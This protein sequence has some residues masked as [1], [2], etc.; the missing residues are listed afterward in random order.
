M[1]RPITIDDNV[2]LKAAREIFLL[3][4]FKARTRLIAETAG[5]SEG[6]VFKRFPSKVDLFIAAMDNH[7][8]DRK[9]IEQLI[10]A[11][12]TNTVEK[13]LTLAVNKIMEHLEVV[14]PRML[15]LKASGVKMPEIFKL[16]NFSSLSEQAAALTTYFQEEIQLNRLEMTRPDIHA[17]M[18]IGAITH[19]V[20]AKQM[21]EHFSCHRTDYIAQLVDLHM[22]GAGKVCAAER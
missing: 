20:M 16:R 7:E 14:I 10:E 4:G 19:F 17:H 6:S 11:P 22:G 9:W 18:L 8:E 2:I 12:G 13:N 15:S 5:V 3:H 21:E 1:S